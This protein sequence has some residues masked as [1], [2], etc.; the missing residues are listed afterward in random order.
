MPVFPAA[1]VWWR[2]RGDR[3]SESRAVA[4][5]SGSE[6]RQGI[7][8]DTQPKTILAFNPDLWKLWRHNFNTSK[9]GKMKGHSIESGNPNA[10]QRAT[11]PA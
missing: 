9:L 1:Y 4:A 10:L 6:A 8:L 11:R 7:L 5:G 3:A 2:R